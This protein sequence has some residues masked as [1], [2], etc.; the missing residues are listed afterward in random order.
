MFITDSHKGL[1]RKYGTLFARLAIGTLFLIAGFSKVVGFEGSVG[2]IGS[3]GLP[4]PE[5]VNIIAIIIEIGGGL[6][7]I[8]GF[9]IAEA[10]S[11]LALFTFLAATLFHSPTTWLGKADAASGMQKTMFLKDFSIL[12]GLLYIIGYGAG[13]G[14]SLSR[15]R[16]NIPP[17][18]S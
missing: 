11:A 18:L 12:G 5:L 7:L 4:M 14:W 8:L 10:A 9:H 3:M 15:K 17:T 16:E 13:D 1:V 6:A 2:Y